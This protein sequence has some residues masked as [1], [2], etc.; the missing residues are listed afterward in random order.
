MLERPD[1]AAMVRFNVLG[2]HVMHLVDFRQPAPWHL[3]ADRIPELNSNLRGLV[4]IVAR[5]GGCQS[6]GCANRNSP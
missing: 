2:R 5:R 3:P 6:I 4:V 1:N